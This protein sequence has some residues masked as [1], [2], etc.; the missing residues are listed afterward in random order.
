ML[1]WTGVDEVPD[2]LP[3]TALTIGTFDGVH[4]GHRILIDQVVA[5]REAGLLPVAVTFDPH[6][7]R[8]L[9]PELAP[10]M[11]CTLSRRLELFEAAGLAGVLVLPFTRELS[12]QSAQDFAQVVLH[13]TMRAGQVLVGRNFRFG[14]RAAGD[15][16]LLAEL[17]GDLDFEVTVVEL[18]GW[19]S[20]DVCSSTVI[21]ELV[22]AGDVAAATQALGHLHRLSGPVVAGDRRGRD[23]GFPTANLELPEHLALPADGVYAGWASLPGGPERAWRAAISVGTNPTFDGRVRRVEAFLLDAEPTLDLYG[24]VLQLDLVE[25][26]RG[27]QR[28]DSVDELVTQMGLDVEQTRSLLTV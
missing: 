20:G 18:A 3:R 6:P 4:R 28:F 15:V 2:D 24:S 27:M 21:R 9:R 17:G 1:V 22:A 25:R 26:I 7:M 12:A 16:A 10:P 14:H 19:A 8:V 5:R 23:L 11:L 13:D